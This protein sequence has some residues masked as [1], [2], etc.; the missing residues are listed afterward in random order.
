MRAAT[1]LSL[2]TMIIQHDK[3][4]SLHGLSLNSGLARPAGAHLLWQVRLAS[5]RAEKDNEI[6]MIFVMAVLIIVEECLAHIPFGG[7]VCEI[8]A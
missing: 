8:I 5:K 7:S 2:M 1:T 4:G 6:I 3:S